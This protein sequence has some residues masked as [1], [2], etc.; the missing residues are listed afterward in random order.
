MG[1]APG[2]GVGEL[3]GDRRRLERRQ[4]GLEIG[5]DRLPVGLG[6]LGV[7][8]R[9]ERECLGDHPAVLEPRQVAP[10]EVVAPADHDLD[11]ASRQVGERQARVRERGHGRVE[12][13]ELLGLAAFDGPRH[14][15]VLG[16][17]EPDRRVEIAAAAAR[18]AIV[19]RSNPGRR[20]SP[21][22]SDRAGT[23]RVQSLPARMFSKYVL[24]S[25][26]PAKAAA[27]ADDRDLRGASPAHETASK[28]LRGRLVRDRFLERSQLARVDDLD[29]ALAAVAQLI[30]QQASGPSS[31]RDHAEAAAAQVALELRD[32]A[33]ARPGPPDHRDDAARPAPVQPVSQ[34]VEDLVGRRI[35]RLA[36]VAE[37]ARR[38]RRR[39]R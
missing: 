38:S 14:D 4:T 5:P 6:P 33:H 29:V 25:D 20:T 1:E 32:H 13:Q 2:R 35:I 19:G 36:H 23:S 37:P 28:R 18:D 26:A 24:R 9:Q 11:A 39:A 34:L 3:A 10:I 16:R 7:K 30:D 15:P 27:H 8:R 31:G 21:G 17:V 12:H 22:P